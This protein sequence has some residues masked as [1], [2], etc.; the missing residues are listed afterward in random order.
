MAH[1]PGFGYVALHHRIQPTAKL[2]AENVGDLELTTHRRVIASGL[3]SPQPQDT[4]VSLTPSST[5]SDLV[6]EPLESTLASAISNNHDS[7]INHV[8]AQTPSNKRPRPHPLSR[9]TT[10]TNDDPDLTDVPDDAPKA[11]KTKAIVHADISIIS[12]DDGG[13]LESEPLNKTHPTADIKAFFTSV[14]LLPGQKKEYMK[15]NSC[16]QGLGGCAKQEKILTAEHSTLRRHAESKHA[17]IYR[18]WCESNNFDSMLPGD[19]KQRNRIAS[20]GGK[21]QQSAVTDHFSPEDL[22]ARP[23]IQAFNHPTFKKMLNIASRAKRNIPL[24][25]PKQSRARIL[26]MFKQQL[27]SLRKCLVGPTVKGEI[28]LTCNAWQASNTDV[29]FAVT[30]HWIEERVPG[31]WTIKHALLGFTQMNTAHNGA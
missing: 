14:P 4:P 28:S 22:D 17:P 13:D 19:S 3:A 23:P 15:C 20:N 9:K 5:I 7:S 26:K 12:I 18:K 8:D 6:G 25:S 16:V 11:K 31:E 29:Y 21:G 27:W 2:T 1:G 30:G 24:L 10:I